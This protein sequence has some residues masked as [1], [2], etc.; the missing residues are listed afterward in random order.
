V[1]PARAGEQLADIAR[2]TGSAWSA[3]EIAVANALAVDVRLA[4]GQTIKVAI[5]EPYR[6]R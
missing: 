2:R 5:P 4:V 3:N 1:V 6:P